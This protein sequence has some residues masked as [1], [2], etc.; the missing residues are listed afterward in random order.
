MI[1]FWGI[2]IFVVSIGHARYTDKTQHSAQVIENA[3]PVTAL[4]QDGEDMR[5]STENGV[6]RR[7]VIYRLRVGSP[8]YFTCYG[9]NLGTW[10]PAYNFHQRPFAALV[11]YTTGIAHLRFYYQ[12]ETTGK[13][14]YV[15]GGSYGVHGRFMN[16][17]QL[18]G[19]CIDRMDLRLDSQLNLNAMRIY[20]GLTSF[21]W[22]GSQ[23]G[24]YYIVRAPSGRCLGDVRM[25]TRGSGI[26]YMCL[27]FNAYKCL[28]CGLNQLRV[29]DKYGRKPTQCANKQEDKKCSHGFYK[30]TSTIG[31]Q[32]CLP[33]K[34]CSE[35]YIIKKS[36][37]ETQNTVCEQ[38]CASGYYLRYDRCQRCKRCSWGYAE[39]SSC[40]K[41]TNTVCKLEKCFFGSYKHTDI[42]TGVQL[43][44]KCTR[45]C[46]WG[47]IM[48]QICSETQD[49]VCERNCR[50]GYYLRN[51][52]CHR[53]LRCPAYFSMVSRCTKTQNTVCKNSLY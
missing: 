48:K 50:A 44:Y 31:V 6:V 16:F 19:S 14:Y 26:S 4:I 10:A 37:S 33:C 38:G 53:C 13:S 8:N 23:V 3:K 28:S 24:N 42:Y 49:T 17:A 11:R 32:T 36:C 51:G 20:G 9:S 39:V 43:C 45:R 30:Q 25:R 41:W 40:T 46:P 5:R 7:R 12:F 35:G 47:Y 34:R 22:F 18:P 15:G 52:D 27:R 21:H 29:C 2:C 1:S